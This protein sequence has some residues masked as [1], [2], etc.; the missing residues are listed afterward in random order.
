MKKLFFAI[1]FILISSGNVFAKATEVLNAVEIPKAS[2]P[3]LDTPVTVKSMTAESMEDFLLKRFQNAVISD[4]SYAASQNQNVSTEPS[5]EAKADQ[6]AAEEE[7]AKST[8][9][10]IY[11]NAIKR[12]AAQEAAAAR[13]DL[14][15]Q[16]T[17][18]ISKPQQQQEWEAPETEVINVFLPPQGRKTMVPAREHIP[19]LFNNIQILPDGLVSFDETIMVVSNGIKLKHGLTKALPKFIFSRMAQKQKIDYTL[20]SVT[21]NN[22]EVPYKIQQQGDQILLVPEQEF[23]LEP[24]V[25][26]YNFKYLADRILWNYPD[27]NELYWDISGSSWNL[28]IT[29]AGASLTT[30]VGTEP[31]GQ[32]VFTGYVN[33]ISADDAMIIKDTDNSWGYAARSPLFVG[34]GMHM[35]ASLPKD[36]V[37]PTTM[38][39][40]VLWL[41]NDYGDIIFSL[42]GLLAIMGSYLLS[43]RFLKKNRGQIKFNFRKN[44]PM[45]RYLATNRFDSRALGAF[46]LELY[47]KNIIDIQNSSEAIILI[48]KTDNLSSLD[49][50][51]RAAVNHLFP[52]RESVLNVNSG[53]IL[54]FQ[55]A[56]KYIEQGVIRRLK[57]FILKLNSGYL[58]FSITMLVV[59]E[60]AIALLGVDWLRS[61]SFLVLNSIA[62]AF[63]I[64]WVN[65]HFGKLYLTI[66]SRLSAIVFLFLSF[67][68]LSAILNPWA[69]LFILL[70]IYTI[71][72]YTGIY[73]R[74]NGLLRSHINEA[75]H[76]GEYLVANKENIMLGR[77]FTSQQANIFAF[78][79]TNDFPC[80]DKITEIYKLDI[81]ENLLKRI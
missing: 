52:G 13:E 64:W 78:G 1:Y 72:S 15:N 55:R 4:E 65:L 36:M 57:N 58:F 42:L 38:T 75:Q 68:L 24:G 6:K 8:F 27:F 59:T 70:S 5:D 46:L 43:W 33:N 81:M 30:P 49:S 67:V 17:A 9:D 40:H 10:K 26:T 73:S 51:E 20:L 2:T 14:T 53:N 45:L 66:I 74:R 54:K 31:L 18:P 19:Y 25:Y 11:E 37:S 34:E 77:D 48:K 79:L 56:Y 7:A 80:Q 12:V 50:Q 28:I 62:L 69:A 41:F 35:V 76:Y 22:Q 63:G 21:I 60:L 23:I 44:A 71:R 29:R 16:E 3:A 61:F 32:N 47:R 39:K